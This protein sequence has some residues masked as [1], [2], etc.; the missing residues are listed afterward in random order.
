MNSN[1]T[2]QLDL[3]GAVVERECII[4]LPLSFEAVIGSEMLEQRQ[5]VTD[6]EERSS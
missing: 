3:T 4:T 2:H 5:Y 6:K 1:E